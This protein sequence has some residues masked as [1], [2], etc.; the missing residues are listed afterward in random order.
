MSDDDRRR[1]NKKYAKGAP[2]RA[3][4]RAHEWLID[5]VEGVPPGGSRTGCGL[6]ENAVWLATRGWQIDAVSFRRRTPAASQL[7]ARHPVTP[8]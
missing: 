5:A 6:G 3:V 1:W 4:A 7:A 8:G 2:R